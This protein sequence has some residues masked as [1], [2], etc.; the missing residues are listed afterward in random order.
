M[1]L[2]TSFCNGTVLKKDITR[3][4]PLWAVYLIGGLL[5]MLTVLSGNDDASYMARALSVTVG[6]FSIINLIYAAVCA[7]MLFGD[8]FQTRMCNALHAMPLRRECWFGTHVMAGLLFSLVP[9]L[10]AT[11]IFAVMMKN[12]AFVAFIW[13]LGM[14]LEYLF[15]FGLAVFSVFCVGNRVAQTAVYGILNFGAAIVYWFVD[16][17][18]APLLYGVQ[19]P[20]APFLLFC[21]VVEMYGNYEMLV[22]ERKPANVNRYDQRYNYRGFGEG[23]EY[24][25]V[26]AILGAVLL[27]LALLLYRRRKLESAGNFIAVRP[28]EPVFAV[29]FTLCAGAVFAAIGQLFFS[30]Y[31][32]YLVVGLVLGWFTGQMLLRRTVKVFHWKTFVKLAIFGLVM[33]GSLIVTSLD[34]VGVTS[35]VPEERE[36]AFVEVDMGSQ[37]AAGSSNYL[38]AETEEDVRQILQA[39]RET[40]A[41]GDPGDRNARMR[42]FTIRYTLKNGRTVSRQYAVYADTTLWKRF[43]ALYGGPEKILGYTDWDSFLDTTEPAVEGCSILELCDQYAQKYDTKVDADK[44]RRELLEAMKKDCEDGTISNQSMAV[45]KGDYVFTV[46]WMPQSGTRWWYVTIYRDCTNTMAW[47]QSYKEIVNMIDN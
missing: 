42:T 1:K 32:V 4:A 8:L 29:V 36:I 14:A 19:I 23:W 6:P 34:P 45:A 46:E 38:K 31:L 11:V 26:C 22:F 30:E 25:T 17:I 3:F 33:G 2:R 16:T 39:H 7:Q 18:Y 9:H 40:V 24:L 43:Q 27:G 41:V 28:L 44:I 37:V 10:I 20:Q 15:F 12:F 13:L 35:W 47:Y 21:P 5:V